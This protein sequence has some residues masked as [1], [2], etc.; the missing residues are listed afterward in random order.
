LWGKHIWVLRQWGGFEN[1]LRF[2]RG[3]KETQALI[4]LA[5]IAA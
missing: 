2:D 4:F 5:V 3:K 1:K